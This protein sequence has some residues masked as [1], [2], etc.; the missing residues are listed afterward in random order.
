[1]DRFSP[2]CVKASGRNNLSN[3]FVICI[4]QREACLGGY[5]V[6]ELD[7]T[8]LFRPY[9]RRCISS[10]EEYSVGLMEEEGSCVLSIILF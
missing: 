6:A 5:W 9:F 4:V 1:M 2:V 8:H 10:A 7:W 3:D